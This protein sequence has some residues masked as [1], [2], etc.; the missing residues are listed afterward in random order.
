MPL[1][2]KKHIFRHWHLFIPLGFLIKFRFFGNYIYIRLF[3]K[4]DNGPEFNFSHILFLDN[5]PFNVSNLV[6]LLTITNTI[7][8]HQRGKAPNTTVFMKVTPTIIKAMSQYFG[9]HYDGVNDV[10][11]YF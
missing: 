4:F 9:C 7:F 11:H 2:L 3:L 5:V 8:K 1:K 6:N 10:S